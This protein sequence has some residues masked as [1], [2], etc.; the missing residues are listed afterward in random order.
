MGR[1]KGKGPTGMLGQPAFTFDES[2]RMATEIVSWVLGRGR[3]CES[4]NREPANEGGLLGRGDWDGTGRGKG[5][6]GNE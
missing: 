2:T 1:G 5:L 3:G 4:Q 6:T